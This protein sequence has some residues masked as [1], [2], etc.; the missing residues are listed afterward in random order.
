M[1][2]ILVTPA[3]AFSG[4]GGDYVARGGSVSISG[5]ASEGDFSSRFA[6][7]PTAGEYEGGL[8]S[9]RF[10]ILGFFGVEPDTDSGLCTS[11]GYTWFE[12]PVTGNN[13]DCCGDDAIDD[14]FYNGSI[15]T[16]DHFCV[17]GSFIN[18]EIDLNESIC[19]HFGHEWYTGSLQGDGTVYARCCGDDDLSDKFF[20]STTYCYEGVSTTDADLLE[21][22]CEGVGGDWFTGSI[23]GVNGP[24]CG[25]DL[26]EY[27]YNGSKSSTTHVCSNSVFYNQGFDE[28][29]EMCEHY[30]HNWLS[31]AFG[32]NSKCCGDDGLADDFSNNT[33]TCCCN[34][35]LINTGDTCDLNSD[36]QD[37]T[38]CVN[39]VYDLELFISDSTTGDAYLMSDYAP[40]FYVTNAGNETICFDNAGVYNISLNYA[41]K[42]ENPECIQPFS[43]GLY[44]FDFGQF[45][46]SDLDDEFNAYALFEYTKTQ[47][48]IGFLRSDFSFRV[49]SPLDI[50]SVEPPITESLP[51]ATNEFSTFL[52]TVK[53][54]GS[55]A[56]SFNPDI[57]TV[58]DALLL[59]KTPERQYT[60]LE[61]EGETFNLLPGQSIVYQVKAVVLSEGDKSATI[62]FNN[63]GECV[64]I[65]DSFIFQLTGFE[66]APGV[67]F[68]QVDALDYASVIILLGLTSFLV[69]KKKL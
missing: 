4:S 23:T 44:V 51:V 65:S 9:G 39:G 34:G 16:T 33:L 36:G 42:P 35:Q 45:K 60:S 15:N 8:Y 1:S 3:L 64:N 41:P 28:N 7:G 66:R 37:D 6:G 55:E 21:S 43:S 29:Q 49:Q 2:L 46:C 57:T 30:S 63:A 22:F 5:R 67:A 68:Y 59:F 69:F 24:C 32:T 27:Y 61:M 54:Q 14:D 13:T 47:G 20:N 31:G 48:E 62:S 56:I 52:L 58:S 11:S 53:N 26:S 18:E 50:T 38:T 17:D 12:D 40:Q 10:S 25:D 19:V